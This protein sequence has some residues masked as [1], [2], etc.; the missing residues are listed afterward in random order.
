MST[1]RNCVG[2]VLF[3]DLGKVLLCARI[4]KKG[5]QW[6]FP[7]GGIEKGEDPKEAALRELFEETSVRS[8]QII[9]NLENPISYTFPKQ[10][11]EKLAAKGKMHIG[12]NMHWF[13]LHFTGTDDEINLQTQIPEFKAYE[14]EDIKSA[15]KHI[16]FFKKGVYYKVCRIFAP[17]IEA[18]IHRAEC[19]V[20]NIEDEENHA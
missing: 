5:Y 8:A 18:Y 16:I 2:I 13:L 7:Q 20:G 3:N 15:P 4:D 12:Q 6:Q 10:I 11:R 14:W 19:L 9:M 17:Y 1:Y